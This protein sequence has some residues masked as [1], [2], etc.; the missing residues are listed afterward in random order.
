M[1]AE[2]LDTKPCAATFLALEVRSNALLPLKGSHSL[3]GSEGRQDA[4]TEVL[5]ELH[6]RV[7]I[8]GA[9]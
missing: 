5:L 4:E 1:V 3:S 8:W 2:G 9:T 6:I 7:S